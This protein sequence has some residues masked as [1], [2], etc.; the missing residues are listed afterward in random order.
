MVRLEH[1]AKTRFV[2]QGK[3]SCSVHELRQV[4]NE[5]LGM[6]QK[7]L[8]QTQFSEVLAQMAGTSIIAAFSPTTVTFATN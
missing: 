3:K 8:N 1:I 7:P 2:D 5:Q 6:G 4:F